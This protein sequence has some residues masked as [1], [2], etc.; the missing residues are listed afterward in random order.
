[1][2]MANATHR[3]AMLTPGQSGRGG[4]QDC[5]PPPSLLLQIFLFCAFLITVAAYVCGQRS[6]AATEHVIALVR[7]AKLDRQTV[8]KGKY[9]AFTK[10]GFQAEEDKNFAAAVSNFQSAVFLQD[11]AE[12]HGTRSP[13]PRSGVG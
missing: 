11:T 3:P 6:D 8:D 2:P 9:L 4:A 12:A 10:L 7:D 13:A 1:M 5:E